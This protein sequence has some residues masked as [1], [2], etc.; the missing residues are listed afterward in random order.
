MRQPP[1]SARLLAY[2]QLKE[3]L[4]HRFPLSELKAGEEKPEDQ[5]QSLRL[6]RG[7]L[8]Y[9]SR[10]NAVLAHYL[11]KRPPNRVMRILQIGAYEVLVE[12]QAAHAVVDQAVRLAQSHNSTAGFKG[13][14][15]AV[16]RKVTTDGAA[17]FAKTK[18]SPLPKAFRGQMKAYDEEDFE[19]IE[20]AHEKGAPTDLTLR[21][22]D[23]VKDWAKELGGE[24]LPTGSIR[25]GSAPQLSSL[26]GYSDGAWW[27]QDAAAAMPARLLEDLTG[28]RV[29][30]IC[31][32]PGGKTMQLAAAGGDVTAIDISEPRMKR[33]KDNLKRTNLDATIVVGD[34]LKFEADKFDAILLDAP[35]SASGTIRRHPDLPIQ[36]SN[37]DLGALLELQRELLRKSVSLL[38]PGGV[39]VYATCSLFPAEGEAQAGFATRE[40]SLS[41]SAVD[42]E[43][44]GLDP[45]W[46]PEPHLLRLRP[47]YWAERDGM[48]GFFMAKFEA[49]G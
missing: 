41:A 49:L 16:L 35:C 11:E 30:D 46:Q 14:V 36:K 19:R 20:T 23:H 17:H 45:S 15:N 43:T 12:G 3:V 39:L 22:R 24:L 34:A 26:K 7:V 32:A 40:L 28:K 8:R 13:L 42:A 21:D 31:A 9:L 48:D 44:F 2:Q 10:I 25:L 1:T 5:A 47:D 37:L 38:K 4:D 33:V 27:V 29:L 18:P 6:V